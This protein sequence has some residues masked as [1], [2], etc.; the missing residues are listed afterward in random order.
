MTGAPLSN[1]EMPTPLIPTTAATKSE[2]A[3]KVKQV[4]KKKA[5]DD[6][7]GLY[8]DP[9]SSPAGE[10]CDKQQSIKQVCVEIFCL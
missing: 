2:D 7:A 6:L 10:G 8:C 5:S 9:V 4:L 3:V 1:S